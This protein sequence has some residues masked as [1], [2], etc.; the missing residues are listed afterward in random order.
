MENF[1]GIKIFLMY[2]AFLLVFRLKDWLFYGSWLALIWAVLLG[3]IIYGIFREKRHIRLF[4]IG[5]L[6]LMLVYDTYSMID[7][8]H[9]F[10]FTPLENSVNI[11]I[12]VVGLL[13]QSF[14][15]I[16]AIVYLV[17]IRQRYHH[18]HKS[19]YVLVSPDD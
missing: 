11:K 16:L 2:I 17:V 9:S 19:K 1:P 5:V 7:F 12:A 10:N 6:T 15:K 8:I 13:F 18:Y 14:H 4:A 3:I